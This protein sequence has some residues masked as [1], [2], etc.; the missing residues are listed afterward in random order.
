MKKTLSTVVAIVLGLMTLTVPAR[1]ADATNGG[2]PPPFTRATLA[3]G[4]ALALLL[5]PELDPA[6]V[7][8]IVTDDFNSVN[9][10]GDAYYCY[11]QVKS[12][13]I[14]IDNNAA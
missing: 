10:N 11:L 6:L 12:G 14:L 3:E 9:H 1:A 2:C 5:H 4:I 8:Q 7:V 13:F